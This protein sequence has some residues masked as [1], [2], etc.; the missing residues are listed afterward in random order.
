MPPRRPPSIGL[1]IVGVVGLVLIVAIP[2]VLALHHPDQLWWAPRCA[3]RDLT[4]LRCPGCGLSRATYHLLHGE[5][6]PAL[7][8]NPLA[9]LVPLMFG[10]MA[11]F[12][13][14]LV[15]RGRVPHIP[16]PSVRVGWALAALLGGFWLYRSIVDLIRG[17]G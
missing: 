4:G 13:G 14:V 5:L 15:L 8:L 11:W 7:Q 2:V 10:G 3:W 12:C 6:W 17:G 16:S 9:P 1:R